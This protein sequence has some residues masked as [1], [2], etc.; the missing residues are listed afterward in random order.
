MQYREHVPASSGFRW[1]IRLVVVVPLLIALFAVMADDSPHVGAVLTLL[2]V[3][4]LM[5][6]L[7]RWMMELTVTVRDGEVEAAFGPIRKRT[8]IAELASV[9]VESY[10]WTRYGGWGIRWGR[11]K[12][13]AWSVPFVGTGVYLEKHD[14]TRWYVSSQSPEH[15]RSVIHEL[16]QSTRAPGADEAS[17][18]S[19]G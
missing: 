1:V 15:L 6:L 14:G 17:R 3:L 4:S 9:T 2:L 19:R 7:D 11:E 5:L 18:G 12:R 16:I 10:Q 13:R 8:P